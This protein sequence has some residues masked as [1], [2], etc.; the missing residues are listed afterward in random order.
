MAAD[1]ILSAQAAVRYPFRCYLLIECEVI[2]EWGNHQFVK[3]YHEVEDVDSPLKIPRDEAFKLAYQLISTQTFPKEAAEDRVRI[4][5]CVWTR[6]IPFEQIEFLQQSKQMYNDQ[7]PPVDQFLQQ[8]QT[9]PTFNQWA[10]QNSQ[11]PF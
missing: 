5:W 2:D 7:V 3:D 11:L 6:S 4:N 1:M 10:Q 8:Q 9:Q